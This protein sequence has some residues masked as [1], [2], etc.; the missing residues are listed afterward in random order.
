MYT[1]GDSNKIKNKTKKALFDILETKKIEIIWQCQFFVVFL[2]IKMNCCSMVKNYEIPEEEPQMVSEPV[3]AVPIEMVQQ[4][5]PVYMLDHE[6]DSCENIPES[7]LNEINQAILEG[8]YELE[9]GE[10]YT[11]G[12]V[13]SKVYKAAYSYESVLETHVESEWGKSDAPCMFSPDELRSV[14]IQSLEDKMNGRLHSHAYVQ[15]MVNSRI[16]AWR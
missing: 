5:I 3:V 7:I 1:T 6:M 4:E 2:H 12:E 10:W 8:D 9:N 16:E 13:M 14:I 11:H 15:K